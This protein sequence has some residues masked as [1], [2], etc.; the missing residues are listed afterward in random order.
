MPRGTGRRAG[1]AA[2]RR[3]G[4]HGLRTHGRDVRLS[5]RG[6]RAGLAGAPGKAL[7]GG[8]LTLA[9]TLATEAVFAAFLA[10]R[11]GLLPHG[12]SYTANPIACAAALA[13]LGLCSDAGRARATWEAPWAHR[14]ERGLAPLRAAQGVLNDCAD[15]G[16]VRALELAVPDGVAPV[17]SRNR[18]L[19][20]RERALDLGVLLRPLGNVLYTVPP[21]L[22][23][24]EV[25]LVARAMVAA[26]DAGLRS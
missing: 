10:R 3:R 11:T 6:D 7:T 17:I 22:S 13:S 5:A 4:P 18:A 19:D 9:A 16:I 23:D 26:V 21:R 8:T 20:L 24:D 15:G 25:D 14:I 1:D 2:D 12:H